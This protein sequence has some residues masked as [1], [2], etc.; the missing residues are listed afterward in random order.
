MNHNNGNTI[1]AAFPGYK[2]LLPIP[3]EHNKPTGIVR[4]PVLAWSISNSPCPNCD[5]QEVVSIT[6]RGQQ[7]LDYGALQLPDGTIE[8]P[9]EDIDIKSE[10]DLLAFWKL[11]AEDDA[12]SHEIPCSATVN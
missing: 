11:K 8:L 9:L 10:A 7:E 6:H 2:W 1:I 4:L 5:V 3:D 12:K